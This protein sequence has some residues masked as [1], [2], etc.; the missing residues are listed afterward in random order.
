MHHSQETHKF[1]S[2]VENPNYGRN[3][4]SLTTLMP[5]RYKSILQQTPV[6]TA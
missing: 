6:S 2:V 1:I 3:G 5:N 4:N